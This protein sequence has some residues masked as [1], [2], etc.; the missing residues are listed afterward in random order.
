MT[1]PV[2]VWLEA[3]SGRQ[4]LTAV[5]ASDLAPGEVEVDTSDLATPSDPL[6]AFITQYG[7]YLDG[8]RSYDDLPAFPGGGT[9]ADEV[10]LEDLVS[11]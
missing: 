5:L 2:Y 3:P 4:Q 6:G 9:R 7:E 1:L 10:A 8:E 11:R